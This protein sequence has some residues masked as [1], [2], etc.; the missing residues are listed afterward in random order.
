MI[1]AAHVAAGCPSLEAL[2]LAELR[3]LV[4][5]L[6]AEVGSLRAEAETQQATITALRA[7]NQA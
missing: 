1:H 5:V 7:E 4:G 2:S 3:A 6:I